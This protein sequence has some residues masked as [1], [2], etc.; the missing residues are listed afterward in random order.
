MFGIIHINKPAGWTS[1]D[2]VNR[3]QGM[4]WPDKAGH[5]GTLDPIA[6]G[7][8]VL[9][10]GHATKLIEHVQRLPK[11]Y[12][13]TFLL[14]RRSPSDDIELE[15]EP[16]PDAPVPTR[17][18]IESA[19]PGFVGHI[20]QT[21]PAYSAIKVAGKPSYKLARGGKAVE[22]KPRP[23]T[24]HA[25]S[26]LRYEYPELELDVACGSGTYI[27]ALGRDLAESLG[28]AA[29]MS[30]LER[31]EIGPFRVEHALRLE[32]LTLEAIQRSLFAPGGLFGQDDSVPITLSQV[33]ELRCGRPLDLVAPPQLTGELAA[34]DPTGG[35]AA[36]VS[37]RPDGRW[38]PTRVFVE[39]ASGW[40]KLEAGAG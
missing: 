11:R 28:T 9:C 20:A 34:L 16:L 2:V 6:T 21:P 36:L 37:R 1:R 8:L 25:L 7:V 30:G 40:A 12:R 18:Q 5:A 14:G 24:I 38:W 23:V 27:R 13:A 39:G 32:G 29:V 33:E 26:A 15:P 22:H 19:L 4:V 31:T 17:P 35:L 10:I 3:V